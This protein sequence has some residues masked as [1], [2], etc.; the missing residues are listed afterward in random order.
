MNHE[1]SRRKKWKGV[2]SLEKETQLFWK[3]TNMVRLNI[4]NFVQADD[5]NF[6]QAWRRFKELLSD[7]P[8]HQA[9]IH[10]FCKGTQVPFQEYLWKLGHE[11]AW[12]YLDSLTEFEHPLG[13]IGEEDSSLSLRELTV[14]API[15]SWKEDF[16][17]LFEEQEAK[18]HTLEMMSRD[19]FRHIGGKLEDLKKMAESLQEGNHC[20]FQ[21]SLYDLV[22]PSLADLVPTPYEKE[23]ESAQGF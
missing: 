5:E 4:E 9:L 14:D 17:L 13:Q 7:L 16:Q 23:A 19:T 3:F 6:F 21:I 22:S 18:V 2:I 8:H 11:K 10:F 15:P 12:T 1:T 20:E